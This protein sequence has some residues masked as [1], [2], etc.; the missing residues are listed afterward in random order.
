VGLDLEESVF[1]HGMTYVAFSRVRSW[2]CLKVAVPP[3]KGNQVKNIVWKE[4]LLPKEPEEVLAVE[5]ED[6]TA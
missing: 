3:T 2:D 1:A 6:L 5:M 4:V